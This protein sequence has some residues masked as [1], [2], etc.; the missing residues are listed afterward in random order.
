[1]NAWDDFRKQ[2]ASRLGLS[3]VADVPYDIFIGPE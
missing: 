1:M 3:R 2:L